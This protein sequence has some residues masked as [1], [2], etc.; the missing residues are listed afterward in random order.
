MTLFQD[1]IS[2]YISFVEG[3]APSS[4]AATNFRLYYDSS[5]HLLKWKNS[6]GTVTTIATGTPLTNPMTTTGDMIYSSSGSTPARLAAVA[7]GQVITSAGTSTAPAY[8]F[9]PGYEFDYVE[10]TTD[11]SITATTEG[12]ANTIVT[13]NAVSYDG[14]TKIVIHFF[15]GRVEPPSG[16][17]LWLVLYDGAGSIGQW[18]LSQSGSTGGRGQKAEY[19]LTPSNASHTYSVRAFVNAATGTAYAGAGGSGVGMPAFIRQTKV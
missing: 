18:D 13:A 7:A 10:K 12:T 5:D 8:A 19:R 17:Y 6:A 1:N 9:P 4:P 11:T 15:C 16:G 2:P 3:S 14:S